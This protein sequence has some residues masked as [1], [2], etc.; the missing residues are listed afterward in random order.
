V[1]GDFNMIYQARDKSNPNLN[2]RLMGSF[3]HTLNI[4]E[5]FELNL[6]NH[7]F[8][9]SNERENPTLV[10]LDRV[11]CNKE[12]DLLLS[13]FHLLALSSSLSDHCPLLLCQQDMP[14]C[15]DSFRF[16]NFWP[17]IPG[18]REVVLQAWQKEVPG[19]SPL[20][21]LH[22][23]L[24][25]TSNELKE[26][27]RSLFGKARLELHMANEVIHQLDIAQERRPL[28]AKER[29]LRCDLK[30]RV[31]VAIERSRRRQ[32]SRLVWLREGDACT[33]FFHLRANK[34]RGRTSYLT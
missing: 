21:K 7:K 24:R 11:F 1:V 23:R 6:Q 9:W 18:F 28:S 8:T 30:T 15:R 4:C 26:W 2:R 13:N 32:A 17:R 34:K 16:E 5:L 12:W 25:N 20:N 19:I 31:L 29:V 22:Y 14:R 27:S 33:R 3:R 10:R